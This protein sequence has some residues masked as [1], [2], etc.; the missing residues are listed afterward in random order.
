MRMYQRLSNTT[1]TVLLLF[2]VFLF[3]T[4]SF[5]QYIYN[6]NSLPKEF[7]LHSFTTV[8][9]VGQRNLNIQDVIVKYESLNPK[10]LKTENDDLGFTE[11]NFWAKVE[12]KNPTDAYLEYY[13]ETARPITDLV[14]LY[15][16]DG[17]SGK[18]VK[19]VS[20]D[21]MRYSERSFDNRKSIFDVTIQPKSNLKLFLHLKSDGEVIKIPVMLHSS[22]SFIKM[23]S[24]EQLFF[25]IFY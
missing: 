19:K 18:I 14:E 23:I 5:S 1:H 6:E 12:L 3:S 10:K 13:L 24:N 17:A 11:D 16:V 21:T 25:G 4:N 15:I 2:F 9:N 8:A 22:D 20:G 7:S